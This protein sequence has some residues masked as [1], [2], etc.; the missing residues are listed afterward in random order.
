[1][2][3]FFSISFLIHF[4]L[5]SMASILF[6]DFKMDSLPTLHM[7]VTLY[8]WMSEEKKVEISIKKEEKILPSPSSGME[9]RE[10]IFHEETPA[11][12]IVPAPSPSVEAE[13]HPEPRLSPPP[14]RAGLRATESVKENPVSE[15]PSL[16]IEDRKEEIRDK[17]EP[18]EKKPIVLASL[19]PETV[20][21]VQREG[22]TDALPSASPGPAAEQETTEVARYPSPSEEEVI[23]VH[24]RYA[25]NPKPFYP[26]E[27]RKKG[28][29]GEV[30]LRV[31]VLSN[32]LVG[33]V[34]VRKSSGHE[35]LDRSALSAVKEWKFLPAKKGENTISFWVNIPIKFQLQ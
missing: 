1:M 3:L 28:F 8:P 18:P 27:A 32:G 24:P 26:R 5:F 33:Q 11:L 30:V 10:Y 23:L 25:V 34:E 7:E 2:K 16:P 4:G 22:P 12:S 15:I 13:V 17:E 20:L 21:T 19:N 9:M 31:E 14:S 29:Q 35:I 6:S